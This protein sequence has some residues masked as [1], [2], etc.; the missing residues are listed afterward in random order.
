MLETD[1]RDLLLDRQND[2]VFENG[3]F[4]W[5]SGIPGV[6]QECRIKMQMFEGEWF[7]NL[8]AGIPYW[9]EILG[10]RPDIAI[11][12]AAAAFNDALLS[13]EDV[14]DVTKMSVIQEPGTRRLLV[15][16]SVRCKFGNTPTDT[17]KF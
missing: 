15:Q 11:T 3:D 6:M 5:S 1:P 7:L 14:K 10:Q 12:A 2:L 9:T 8:E 4:K 17:L 13:T 16:W